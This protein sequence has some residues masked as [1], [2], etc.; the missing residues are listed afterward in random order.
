[1][2]AAEAVI[3]STRARHEVANPAAPRLDL[4]S[5]FR[6]GRTTA[7]TC[8][9]AAGRLPNPENGCNAVQEGGCS[10]SIAM[11]PLLHV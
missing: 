5:S 11:S 9:F 4:R 3:M 8:D 10:M 6:F 1:M 7:L 2:I